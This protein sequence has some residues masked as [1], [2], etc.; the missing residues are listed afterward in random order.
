MLA[1]LAGPAYP[2]LR[3][4]N[5]T[6]SVVFDPDAQQPA[7]YVLAFS[8]MPPDVD[9]LFP[10]STRVGA[11]YFPQ[12]IDGGAAPPAFLAYRLA[13]PQVRSQVDALLADPRL[14][15]VAGRIPGVLQPL[16]ARLDGP[17]KPGGELR[18]TMI[19]RVQ[20]HPPPGDYQLVAQLLDHRWQTLSDVEGLGYPVAEWRPGDVV[21]S[22]FVIPVPA[23]TPPGQDKVQVALYDRHSGV[24]LPVADGVPGIAGLVLGDARV[25]AATP[26]PAPDLALGARLGSDVELIGFDRPRAEGSDGLATTLH[27]QTQRPLDQDYTVFVQL[28][29]PAGKLVAQS[30]S[31][32]ADSALPTSAWLPGEV[33]LDAHRLPLRPDLPPGRYRLIAGLYLLSTGQRLPV[34]GGGDFADLGTVTLPLK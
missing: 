16:G 1:Q 17:V 2:A 5:G 21:W 7:L 14:R 20:G 13:P 23:N 22:Q 4:F 24:R 28:L 6:Q 34:S 26:P 10:P 15:P 8:G 12:G 11:A 9:A 33:V 30:D 27:W 29:D 3:W 25:V 18:A 32:P 31:W 19:W